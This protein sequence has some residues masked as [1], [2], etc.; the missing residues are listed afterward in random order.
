MWDG[1][2]AASGLS[3]EAFAASFAH[4]RD[5]HAQIG[6][7]GAIEGAAGQRYVTVPVTV[8][9]TTRN[10]ARFA[11]EGQVTLHR[12]GDIDG[13]REAQRRW[14]IYRTGVPPHPAA[15]PT[16]PAATPSGG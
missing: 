1:A 7:P 9:G 16:P 6:A 11:T 8:T 13:A 4:Y 15:T 10:G 12:V 14:R 3:P 5:Y 2:G